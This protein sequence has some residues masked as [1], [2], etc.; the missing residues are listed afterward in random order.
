M[1]TKLQRAERLAAKWQYEGNVAA[2][3][4]DKA[5]AEACYE[6]SQKH[7]DAMNRELGNGDGTRR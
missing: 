1:E 2:E 5:R 4:G 7:R 3:R 6:K